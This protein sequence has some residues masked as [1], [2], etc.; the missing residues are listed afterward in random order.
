MFSALAATATPKKP[1]FCRALSNCVDV[2]Y[3]MAAIDTLSREAITEIVSSA[4]GICISIFLPT[5]RSGAQTLQ[6]PIH[7]K[8]LL[9]EAED[10][11]V[12]RELRWNEVEALTSEAHALVRDDG[13]WQHQR[14]GL[15]IFLS[16]GQQRVFRL[17]IEVP[18]RQFVGEAFDITPLLPMLANDGRFYILAVSENDVRLLDA[19]RYGFYEVD[20]EGVPK[21]MAEALW[22]DDH[23]RQ[24]QFHSGAGAS[25]KGGGR[26]AMYFGT[27]DENSMEQHKVDY[28]RYFDK[29]DA[30]LATTFKQY[31]APVVLAGVGYLLPIYRTANNNGHLLEGEVHGNKDRSTAE[32]IHKA[33][34]EV[35]ELHFAAAESAAKDRFHQLLGTG[36]ASAQHDEVLTAAESGRLDTLF[37]S[38]DP[39]QDPAEINRCAINSLANGGEVFALA[40]SSMPTEEPLSA[41][42]RY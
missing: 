38:L 33:A 41:I 12:K 39:G 35:A 11:L 24:L 17:P 16:E 22:A 23:E 37:L 9:K 7:L 29:V 8:N 42:F 40:P 1:T 10:E 31:P 21:G 6:G 36:L 2:E 30:A 18:A 14:D 34:W 3:P 27:G 19:T 5:Y 4:S 26:S 13:F 25:P 15:A 28:K 32:D 20:I